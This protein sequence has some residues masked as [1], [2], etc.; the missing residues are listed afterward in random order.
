MWLGGANPWAHSSDLPTPGDSTPT[1]LARR[2]WSRHQALGA[3]CRTTAD[4][5]LPSGH[6]PEDL[7]WSSH[8]TQK[9]KK[10]SYQWL[11]NWHSSAILP[12]A[13]RF[14]V[15]AGTGQPSVSILW[16]GEMESLICNFYLSVAACIL[17]EQIRPWDKVA[18]CW[19]IKQPT[20]KQSKLCPSDFKEVMQMFVQNPLIIVQLCINRANNSTLE[21]WVLF[22]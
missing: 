6:W 12:G 2:H 10:K 5:G 15:G 16:L 19:G 1:V 18:C 4:S 8:R 7:A 20:N 13:W 22:R 17:S 9:K 21:R 14:R 3:S 11:K